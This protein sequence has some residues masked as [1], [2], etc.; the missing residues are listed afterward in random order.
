ME[1]N[2]HDLLLPCHYLRTAFRE[3][4][5]MGSSSYNDSRALG[6]KPGLLIKE[7]GQSFLLPLPCDCILPD[8]AMA[9]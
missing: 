3:E 9:F 5:K 8:S 6:K 4:G 2:L 1:H 7:H